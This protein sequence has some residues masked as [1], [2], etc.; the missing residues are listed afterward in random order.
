MALSSANMAL[1]NILQKIDLESE[2]EIQEIKK[3]S[4][5]QIKKNLSQ[6]A[7]QA[8]KIKAKSIENFQKEKLEEAKQILRDKKNDGR[9]IVLERKREILDIV[10]QEALEKLKKSD[11]EEL[12][13][14]LKKNLPQ[15]GKIID[16]KNNGFKFVS[17]NFEI[18]NTLLSLVAQ[19][20]QKLEIK[21]AK[22]LYA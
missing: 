16:D 6:A 7:E 18:D 13:I 1:Q 17:E 14:K 19:A 9:R 8:G 4:G 12:I 2:K 10:F 11:T 21:I 5:K 3:Q 15:D 22:M 20:R